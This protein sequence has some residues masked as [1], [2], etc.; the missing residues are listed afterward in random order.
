VNLDKRPSKPADEPE[1]GL[2]ERY[3]GSPFS[4]I[5]AGPQA[6]KCDLNSHNRIHKPHNA[7]VF[8]KRFQ[9]FLVSKRIDAPQTDRHPDRKGKDRIPKRPLP[10]KICTLRDDD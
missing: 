2:P 9:R 3:L 1:K 10:N 6:Q 8:Q 4:Y 5:K 7:G